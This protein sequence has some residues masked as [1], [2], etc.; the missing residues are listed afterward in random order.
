MLGV[1]RKLISKAKDRNE[2]GEICACIHRLW[3][4]AFHSPAFLMACLTVSPNSLSVSASL[5]MV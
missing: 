2:K 5:G 1:W 3:N 4:K